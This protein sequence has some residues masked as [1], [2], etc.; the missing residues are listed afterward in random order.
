MTASAWSGFHREI[1]QARLLIAGG[2]GYRKAKKTDASKTLEQTPGI[3][4]LGRV[5]RSELSHIYSL[6]DALFFVKEGGPM[7][8]SSKIYEYIATGLP[9][10]ALGAA[11]VGARIEI[12][13]YPRVHWGDLADPVSGTRALVAAAADA[14]HSPALAHHSEQVL[15]FNR[16]TTFEREAAG[17][18]SGAIGS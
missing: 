4:L 13:D 12:S 14:A 8:T 17:V 1:P 15:S 2:I 7:V 11:D 6:A 16:A 10:A 3:E 18:I 9:I 5:Q